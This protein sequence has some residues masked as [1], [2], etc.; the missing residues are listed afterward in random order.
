[1][2]ALTVLLLSSLIV[3]CSSGAANN[4]KAEAKINPLFFQNDDRLPVTSAAHS[5]WDAIGQ[6]ETRSGKLCTATLISP[7]LALTAGHCLVT[8]PDKA[9]VLRFISG[10]QGWRYELHDIDTDVDP[11]LGRKLEVSD[12]SWIVPAEAA[13]H[14]YGLII[15]H[16]PPSAIT[17]LPLFAGDHDKLKKAIESA[18]YRVTLAGYPQDHVNT[19]YVHNHC[20]ITGWAQR[21]ILSHQCDTLPGDSGSPLLL[22]NN[23]YWQIIA[24]QSSAPAAENRYRA[25]NRAI[26]VT[27]FSGRVVEKSQRP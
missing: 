18:H 25:D 23:I 13:P 7:H 9:T 8:P 6:L 2:R 5:P 15:L 26:A 12:D 24:V 22:S 19:L 21:N 14:D 27:I 4:S 10:K 17:P 16:N 11:E 3:P 20:K 1:M